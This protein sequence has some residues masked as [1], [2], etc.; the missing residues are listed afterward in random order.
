MYQRPIALGS[1]SSTTLKTDL[2]PT[3]SCRSKQYLKHPI[4]HR[5]NLD[6]RTRD[7]VVE[8]K[9][10]LQARPTVVLLVVLLV[11]VPQEV[12]GVHL[13]TLVLEA[14]EAV[15]VAGTG[16]LER[17]HESSHKMQCEW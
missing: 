4:A 6:T 17:D 12:K 3:N 10:M 14:L 8:A 16:R 11:L 1:S 2:L 15:V 9:A 5:S 7:L 13:V